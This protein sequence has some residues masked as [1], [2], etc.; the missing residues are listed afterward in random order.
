ME[1]FAKVTQSLFSP[2]IVIL[3]PAGVCWVLMWHS[4]SWIPDSAAGKSSSAKEQPDLVSCTV[5]CSELQPHLRVLGAFPEIKGCW[6]VFGNDP[7]MK[8][9]GQQHFPIFIC[10]CPRGVESSDA[11]ILLLAFPKVQFCQSFSPF[12]QLLEFCEL[13]KKRDFNCS[14]FSKGAKIV[15]GPKAQLT[16]VQFKCVCEK[17]LALWSSA[18]SG[19]A[20]AW[21]ATWF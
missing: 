3:R 9:L 7:Q 6:C 12:E 5:N 8:C 16:N 21:I 20:G 19:A 18:C 1:L 15:A 10:L 14:Y 2:Q 13:W 4:T 11:L 17:H